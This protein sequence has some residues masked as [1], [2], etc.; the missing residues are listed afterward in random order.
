MQS[1]RIGGNALRSAVIAPATVAAQ[2]Y[3]SKPIRSS[4]LMFPAASSTMSGAIWRSG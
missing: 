4:C 1:L 2:T 3:P